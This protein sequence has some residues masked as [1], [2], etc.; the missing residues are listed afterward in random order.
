[1]DRHERRQQRMR[2]AGASSVQENFGFSFAGLAPKAFAKQASLPPQPA[3]R[4]PTPAR[5]TPRASVQRTVTPKLGKRKRGVV[6]V[7]ASVDDGEPDDLS[8]DRDDD[9]HSVEK[10][11][12]VV[13]TAS[14]MRDILDDEPDELSFLEEGQSTAKRVSHVTV[15]EKTPIA[16]RISNMAIRPTV[17]YARRSKSIDASP[18]TPGLLPIRPR[19]SSASRFGPEFTTPRVAQDGDDSED[20]LSPPVK[21]STV[22]VV[23][24]EHR[25]LPPSE[26]AEDA[27]QDM[28][29]LSP[30][31]RSSRKQAPPTNEEDAGQD[32]DELSSPAQPSKSQPPAPAPARAGRSRRIVLDEEDQAQVTPAA[33]KPRRKKTNL[34]SPEQAGIEEDAPDEISPEAA[35]TRTRPQTAVRREEQLPDVLSAEESDN[36]ELDVEEQAIAPKRKHSRTTKS[37]AGEPPRKRQRFG[38]PKRSISVMRIKGSTVRGI[39]VAD[40]TRTILE[41]NMD[42]RVSRM[43]EKLQNTQDS[44]R[45]RQI[46]TEINL[47]LAFKESLNEKLLDLQDAND[48][49]SAG[50]QKRKALKNKNVERR[51]D[52]L[53][54]Q[55]SRHEIALELDDEQAVFDADKKEMEA[56]STLSANLFEIQAAIQ[57]G[58]ERAR[59]Q[60]REDEGPNVPLS[61]LLETVGQSVGSVS[62]GLLAGMR[63]FNSGLE[64]AAGWLEGRA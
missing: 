24:Y 52:I 25:S 8:P 7:Q 35:Q 1:M 2:G 29:E 27:N 17:K 12:R 13:G 30:P 33:T 22:R 23:A 40:T 18:T 4:T 62:G 49:L 41:Q 64:R 59:Q 38:G 36:Y 55:N 48:T 43:A 63:E 54:L 60:G 39:T 58:R 16:D 57:S 56:K 47:V 11:R 21:V 19:T 15:A 53:A 45:R 10:S 42:H 9:V 44:S 6:P 32:M 20:E 3:R 31:V 5:K 26:D 50:F 14:P 61:M 28:D 51:K 46:R 37:T 34:V